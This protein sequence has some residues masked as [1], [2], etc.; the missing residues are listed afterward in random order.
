MKRSW[1][2]NIILCF[3]MISCFSAC[4]KTAKNSTDDIS[5]GEASESVEE[6]FSTIPSWGLKYELSLDGSY[7]IVTGM[8]TCSEKDIV[9]DSTCNGFPVQEIKDRAFMACDIT[10]VVIPDSVRTI[11]IGAF[12][13]CRSMSRLKIGNSVTTI[14]ED[15][16]TYCVALK[17]LSL[18]DSVT[19]IGDYSFSNCDLLESLSI[20]SGMDLIGYRAFDYCIALQNITYNGTKDGWNMVKKGRW[21]TG[22]PATKIVCTDGDF[23]LTSD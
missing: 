10:S 17:K 9:I 7:Y 23:A 3:I 6:E 12:A 11:G 13:E 20:G 16:F 19:S 21:N 14:G 8:G 4:G 5:L 15:A 1:I 18:P 22:V 2:K